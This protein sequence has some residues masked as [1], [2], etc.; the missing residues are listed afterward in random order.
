ML[1]EPY[2]RLFWEKAVGGFQGAGTLPLQQKLDKKLKSKVSPQRY[3]QEFAEFERC[4]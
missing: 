4:Y 2:W 3:L 1:L